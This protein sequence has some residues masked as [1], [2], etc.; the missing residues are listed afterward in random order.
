[1]KGDLLTSLNDEQKRALL[2]TNGPNLILAGAGSGKTRVL[3]HKVAYLILEKRIHPQ[4]ILMV[5]FTNK[6]AIEMKERIRK[7]LNSE[8]KILPFAGTFH[9]LCAKILRIDGGRIGISPKFSI[10]DENDSLDLV[11]EIM[12][13]KNISTKEISPHSVRNTI[14]QIKNELI[15][16]AEYGQIARGHFQEVVYSIYSI[17]QK[18]LRES[19]ALDFDDLLFETV[20]LFR[21]SDDILGKYQ[22]RFQYILVDEY[23][24]TN[25]AQY[26]LT[27]LLSKRF[28][29]ITVVGDASQSIYGWRG[30]NYRNIT[31]FEKDFPDVKVFYLERNYRSTENILEAANA[32]IAKNTNHPI[33]K[34]W[35]DKGK[36]ES[37]SLYEARNEHAEVEYILR[38]V[39]RMMRDNRTL[40]Y[41][42][43]VIL[44][45]TNAQSRV[46]E[47]VF[48]HAGIPYILVGGVRFY[49][50]REIKDVVSYLR[51]VANRADSVSRKR[52]EKLGKRRFE[53]FLEALES[54]DL[55]QKSSIEILD[56]ILEKTEYLSLYDEKIEEDRQRLENIKEL[57]SVATEFPDLTLFLE[58]VSLV[59]QEYM[60][61]D[62]LTFDEKKHKNAITLMT[63]HAAKGLEFPV[64]F[65]VGMEDGLFPHSRSLLDREQLEEERRLCYVGFTRAMKKLYLTYAT[66][67]L[68]FGTRTSNIVSQFILDLP[69]DI[70]QTSIAADDIF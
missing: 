58:N 42:S 52:I 56:F 31:T 4:N 37:I 20:R 33:L 16:P 66:H 27:K 49:E 69:E 53:K 9:S 62:A 22:N 68:F 70:V 36:G 40:T 61:D 1:M 24:D 3:T 14:S 64:V 28:R 6:A 34:L 50:R 54:I 11:R 10:Y 39:A 44:Y 26:T 65:I 38:E 32:V 48:L 46:I 59:E 15:T 19:Q 5:T 60:P 23:Q 51:F 35:T 7:L 57:R 21:E 30:A 25:T 12:K 8:G 13:E 29:N 45:R 47:E 43:F 17:Y 63:L 55:S 18:R 41:K 2:S 67:R